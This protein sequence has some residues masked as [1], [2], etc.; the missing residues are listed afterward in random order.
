MESKHKFDKVTAAGVLVAFGIIYGDIGTSPLYV[1]QAIILNE[2]ITED[3]IYG[4]ISCIFWTLTLQTTV[5]YVILILRADNKGEGGIFALYALVRKHAKWLTVPAVI[6]GSTL[7]A[8]GIITPPISV[9]SAV[10]GLQLIYPNI[11]T[12]PIV[13]GILTLIFVIQAFGTKVVGRAFGPIMITWFVMLGVLGLFQILEHPEILKALSPAYGYD[14]ITKHPGGFWILGAVFLCTTGAEALYSDLG[15][16]GRENI[17]VSWIFVKIC[18]LLNYFGQGAW[19]LSEMGNLLEARKPFYEIMPEWWLLPGVVI[20]T[21][22]AIIA[23]QAVITGSFTLISEAIRLNFWPKVR[24]I[25]PSDQKGQLYVPSINWL[26]WLGCCGVVLYFG[27]SSNMEAAYGLAITLTMIMTTI[28]FSY[29]LYIKRVNLWIVII[30]MLFYLCIEG[31]FLGANLLKFTHGGWFTILIGTV[32]AGLMTVWLKAFY[33]KLRLTEYTKLE[34]YLPALH[35]LSRDISIPKYT[36]HLVFMTNASRATE[37]ETKVIYS[38]FQKRP[39]RADV[40]WFI[41]V[42]ITDDPY[43]ME[44]KVL[45][46]D[47]N[48]DNV[49]KINFRLGFRVD[50]RIN[51]F[52]R[53]VVEDMVMN[54]EVDITSRY[55]SLSRQNITGDFRFVVLERFLSFENDLPLF[56]QL[57]MKTYFFV[58]D[59]T[60]AEDKWFGLDSSSVKIEKVPLIIRPVENVKLRRV[61][62]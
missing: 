57:V 18:L 33:I 45:S 26:L 29:Y 5:K 20:A 40:Y 35:E 53:K 31:M 30:F 21:L 32:V 2:I 39:K 24:L 13:I 10:E 7:L 44:Y 14:L 28:L 3:I 37:I 51:M 9:S 8:D 43:T 22:A 12:V 34:K 16:C 23:S 27:K 19:L 6:G 61:F 36:T 47:D 55:E 38:I 4:A 59:F 41:H 17:R 11:Q 25:Y 49:I 54:K 56:E 50:Q 58:K 1:M 62:S 48:N 52:F 42:D 46:D 15:H 60:T